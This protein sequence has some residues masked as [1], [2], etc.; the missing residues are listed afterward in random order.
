ME[1]T[2]TP[3]SPGTNQPILFSTNKDSVKT[4]YDKLSQEEQSIVDNYRSK[5][6]ILDTNSISDFGS[7]A[8]GKNFKFIKSTY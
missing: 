1:S 7:D 2:A 3:K 6:N 5:L 8:T 4:E